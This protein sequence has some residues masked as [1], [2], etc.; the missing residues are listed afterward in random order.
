MGPALPSRREG[1]SPQD[2]TALLSKAHGAPPL[3]S[4]TE[5]SGFTQIEADPVWHGM[6]LDLMLGNLERPLWGWADPQAIYALDYWA[7]L[8]SKLTFVLVYGEPEWVL[9]GR[10]EGDDGD[11]ATSPLSVGHLLGNWTAYNSALLRFRLRH[12]GRSVL[13]HAQQIE[14]ASSVSVERLQ[15]LLG[16]GAPVEAVAPLVSPDG[17]RPS[18]PV[19]QAALP[20]AVH[21]ALASAGMHPEQA[22]E[23]LRADAVE[24]YLID[25]VLEQYP[26]TLQLYAELQSVA[27]LPLDAPRADGVARAAWD[28][29]LRQRGLASRLLVGLHSVARDAGEDLAWVHRQLRDE[30]ATRFAALEEAKQRTDQLEAQ[31]SVTEAQ[32]C[33]VTDESELLLTQLHRVQEELERF[34]LRLKNIQ[35][36]KDIVDAELAR[37]K[38]RIWSLRPELRRAKADLRLVRS[39]LQARVAAAPDLKV[40]PSRALLGTLFRRLLIK[41]LPK[42][43]LGR[44]R[45]Y[46]QRRR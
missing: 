42:P 37:S 16:G 13:V 10:G 30:R 21:A 45:A 20:K 23:V 24:R 35:A 17:T 34:H 9:M 32:R 41:V 5:D 18:F 19:M 40:V 2:I 29:L 3:E 36:E 27:D 8:D 15:T 28:A 1:L 31:L 14:P 4:V 46:R 38:Q 33:D 6:A 44:V 43:V 22:A 26:A 39:D 11:A 12:P 7:E 25:G